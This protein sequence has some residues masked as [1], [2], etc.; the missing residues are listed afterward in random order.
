MRTRSLAVDTKAHEASTDT[1]R[2]DQQPEISG[3]VLGIEIGWDEGD[4]LFSISAVIGTERRDYKH[5]ER[6]LLGRTKTKAEAFEWQINAA[7]QHNCQG[8]STYEASIRS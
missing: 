7:T 4:K 2:T 6:V 5:G 1:G 8:W 3:N